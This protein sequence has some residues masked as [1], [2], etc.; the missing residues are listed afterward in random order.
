MHIIRGNDI[1]Y[2]PASHERPDAP[3]VLKK[4]L[5]QAADLIE[6]RVQMINWALLPAGRSFQA[7]YH[8]DMQEIFILVQG[9]TCIDIEGESAVMNTGDAVFV[10]VAAVHTMHNP[11]DKDAAYIAIGITQ[12]RGGKTVVVEEA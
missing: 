8:E 7:H 12:G 10:P 2:I 4:V 3:G 9:S 11:G 6:G 1:D 5:V